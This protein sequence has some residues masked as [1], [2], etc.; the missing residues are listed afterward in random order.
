MSALATGLWRLVSA[1][2]LAT[3]ISSGTAFA[4]A[5]AHPPANPSPMGHGM[6]MGGKEGMPPSGAEQQ[7][8][9]KPQGMGQGMPMEAGRDMRM[10]E[11]MKPM[12]RSMMSEMMAG[13]GMGPMV[14][15]GGMLANRTEGALAFLKAEL[16]I[17]D[18]QEHVWSTFAGSIRASMQKFRDAT[19][20]PG[21]TMEGWLGG[22]EAREKVLT[23]QVDAIKAVRAAATPL[24]AALTP[25]QKKKADELTMGSTTIR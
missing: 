11:G 17:A 9:G 5:P 16:K 22:L 8:P 12:M 14:G 6:G 18:S 19:S 4:Q 25:D 23:A 15:L 13:S 21:F 2:A 10:M 3:M 24:Y 20:A 7:A 1:A